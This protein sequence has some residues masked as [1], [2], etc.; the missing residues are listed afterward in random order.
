M[1]TINTNQ[2]RRVRIIA[3]PLIFTIIGFV[4]FNIG[5]IGEAE[6]KTTSNKDI[7]SGLPNAKIKDFDENTK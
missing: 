2:V 6:A 7:I 4:G 1:N 3:I 5:I